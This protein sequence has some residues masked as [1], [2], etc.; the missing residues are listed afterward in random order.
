MRIHL[1]VHFH[2]LAGDV[3]QVQAQTLRGDDEQRQDQHADDREMP[4]EREHHDK[5]ADCFDQV[6]DDI[7]H[8][9]ADGVLRTD[10]IVIEAAHQLA[11]FCVGK[12]S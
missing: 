2:A 5:Q 6:G 8:G 12:E 7:D 11:G 1:R 3:A 9:V 10:H 4:F